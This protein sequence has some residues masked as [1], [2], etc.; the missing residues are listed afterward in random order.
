MESIQRELPRRTNENQNGISDKN[1]AKNLLVL[2]KIG[3][4]FIGRILYLSKGTWNK[5]FG[6]PEDTQNLVDLEFRSQNLLSM[7]KIGIKKF[8]F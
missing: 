7:L 5:L 1:S 3:T 8:T 6:P 4:H 2:A